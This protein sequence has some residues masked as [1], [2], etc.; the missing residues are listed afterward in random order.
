MVLF[1]FNT[2]IYVFLLLCLCILIVCLCMATVTEVFPCFF[3]SCKANTRKDGARPALF[4]IFVLFYVFLCVVLCIV[5]VYMCTL[6]LPPG[7]YPIAG[8]KYIIKPVTTV[9]R[10]SK[11][12]KVFYILISYRYVEM[13]RGGETLHKS[14]FV[15]DT[16]GNKV[17]I[18]Y[19][20]LGNWDTITLQGFVGTALL[21]LVGM[22]CSL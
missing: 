20:A 5:C 17:G 16:Y 1:L 3:L 12:R 7:G 10:R 2:V 8:N 22:E 14:R 11:C 6:L 18:W 21:S 15:P 9:L 19:I 13:Q 4:L